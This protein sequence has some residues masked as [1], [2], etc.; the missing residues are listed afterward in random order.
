MMFPQI[1]RQLTNKMKEEDQQTITDRDNKIQA[2]EFMNE[3]HQQ[4]ILRL[5]EEINDLIANRYVAPV[6]VLTTCYASSKRTADKFAHT[7]LFDV[8]TGSWKKVSDGLNFFTQ[9]WRW[10]TN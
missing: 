1:R 6:V 4:E 7:T 3:K 8:S 10:L 9:I 2:L 5:N